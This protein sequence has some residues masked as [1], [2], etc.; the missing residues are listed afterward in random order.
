[1]ERYADR[2][3]LV[4]IIVAH[5]YILLVVSIETFSLP[6]TDLHYP[7]ITVCKT[8]PYDVGEYL[9]AVYDNFQMECCA[10]GNEDTQLLREHFP[11]F[12][13]FVYNEARNSHKLI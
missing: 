13:S 4:N 11:G 7:A 8:S 5:F 1:M 6:A 12:F 10:T 2:F 9:R 3:G